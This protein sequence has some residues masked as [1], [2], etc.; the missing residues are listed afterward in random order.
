MGIPGGAQV[1]IPRE[2]FNVPHALFKAVEGEGIVDAIVQNTPIFVQTS[3]F[4]STLAGSIVLNNAKLTDIDITVGSITGHVMLE[5]CPKTTKT[6]ESWG[7]GNVYKNI[8]PIGMYTQGDIHAAHKPS[9]LLDNQGKIFGKM[10][11]QYADYAVSQFVSVWDHGAMGDGKTDDTDAIKAVLE[12]V[13]NAS[14]AC[15]WN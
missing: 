5:G 6:V 2:T 4:N 9:T 3:A 7:Q 12:T 13:C 8:V 11:P 10:H 15:P 1:R 14:R